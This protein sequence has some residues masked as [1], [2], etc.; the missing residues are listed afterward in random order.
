[1]E[2]LVQLSN[3]LKVKGHCRIELY[4]AETGELCEAAEGDNF[5]N[6]L[7]ANTI[8]KQVQKLIVAGGI[9]NGGLDLP[10][11]NNNTLDGL[12]RYLVLTDYSGAESP[13]TEVSIPGNMIGWANRS[14]YAGGSSVEGSI[15]VSESFG[16]ETLAH[17]VFDFPTNC[18]NGTINSICWSYVY[19]ESQGY[20]MMP[21]KMCGSNWVWLTRFV[22]T[23][24]Y[25]AAGDGYFWGYLANGSNYTVYKIDP[26]QAYA[27]ISSFNLPTAPMGVRFVETGGYLYYTNQSNYVVKYNISAGTYVQSATAIAV[28][29]TYTHLVQATDGTYLYM[30]WIGGYAAM[31][32]RMSDLTLMESGKYIQVNGTFSAFYFVYISGQLYIIN[33]YNPSQGLYTVNWTTGSGSITANFAAPFYG[34]SSLFSDGTTLYSTYTEQFYSING[35][36]T[37]LMNLASNPAGITGIAN[38]NLMARKLLGSPIVK[39][40]SKTMKIIYEFTFS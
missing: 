33:T 25:V 9:P 32:V 28:W 7:L 24:T 40:S 34:D 17:W 19:P 37:S 31:R 8:F 10:N 22:R 15:N 36:G 26:T 39:T 2:E 35:N 1:V 3:L 4:D 30:S 27:E 14:S 21:G 38:Y 11:I 5:V 16:N 12:F 13:S 23:Y 6:P 20:Y 18:A 29:N